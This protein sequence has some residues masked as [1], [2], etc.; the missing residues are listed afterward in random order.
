[1]AALMADLNRI[2]HQIARTHMLLRHGGRLRFTAPEKYGA[3]EDS[4]VDEPSGIY[5]LA[6]TI[7]ALG[8]GE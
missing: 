3:D 2:R 8:V 7:Y 1:M 6:M 4:F 5:S